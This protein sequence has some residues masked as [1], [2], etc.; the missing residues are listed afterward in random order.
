MRGRSDFTPSKWQSNI[1]SGFHVATY[2]SIISSPVTCM[3][4][5]HE[6]SRWTLAVGGANGDIRVYQ[7]NDDSE[8]G[9]EVLAA[10][11]PHKGAVTALLLGNESAITAPMIAREPSYDHF[12]LKSSS[13]ERDAVSKKSR[14]T[15][16]IRKLWMPKQTATNGSILHICCVNVLSSR[17]DDFWNIAWNSSRR[18]FNCEASMLQS[19]TIC[20]NYSVRTCSVRVFAINM[21]AKSHVSR[22]FAAL[23]S[24]QG[25]LTDL[26]KCGI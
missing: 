14:A 15:D 26:S 20:A 21:P 2:K 19:L 7:S 11:A 1:K 6:G 3:G 24:L 8:K 5:R 9:M 25:V 10:T 13:D 16:Y 17:Y 22:Q 18:R 4:G 12:E 23:S